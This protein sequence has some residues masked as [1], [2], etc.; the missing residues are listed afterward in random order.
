[1]LH[2]SSHNG[3]LA[4]SWDS[5][6]LLTETQVKTLS[7]VITCMSEQIHEKSK[8]TNQI[9]MRTCIQTKQFTCPI[10]ACYSVYKACLGFC[11]SALNFL[12]KFVFSHFSPLALTLIQREKGIWSNRISMIYSFAWITSQKISMGIQFIS[13]SIATRLMH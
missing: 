10:P 8:T 11:I 6:V 2:S 5:W 1:M 7:Q 9:C 3:V 12:N 4:H 13:S